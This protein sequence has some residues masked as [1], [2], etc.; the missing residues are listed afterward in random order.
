MDRK[1]VIKAFVKEN[2]LV[3]HQI[4]SYNDG[5][6]EPGGDQLGPFY[7]LETSSPALPLEPGQSITHV[8]DTIHFDCCPKTLGP[9]AET[10]FGVTIEEIEQAFE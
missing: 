2:S 5:P 7:E 3:D 8:S 6:T 10:V 4:H 9:I 1:D